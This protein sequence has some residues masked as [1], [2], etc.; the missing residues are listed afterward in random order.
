MGA[1]RV[2]VLALGS[3]V[4]ALVAFVGP[5]AVAGPDAPGADESGFT[6]SV[7]GERSGR[8][9]PTLTSAADLVAVA[10]RHAAR[11]AAEQRLH[12]NPN[13]T[14][15]VQGWQKVGE[16]VGVGPDTASVH[17][18]FMGSSTHR[19]QILD[20]GY[21]RAQ[22]LE[23]V[24]GMA[25]SLMANYAGHLVDAPVDPPFQPHAW[26]GAQVGAGVPA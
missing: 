19:A 8:G 10:R 6:A 7:N 21:T 18:A 3:V 14:A 22:A 20:A 26:H 1:R 4:V 13:L 25:F 11:M 24:L 15:E 17:G 16:N 9:L 12:H 23:V 2:A 5:H